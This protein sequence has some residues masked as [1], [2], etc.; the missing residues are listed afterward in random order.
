MSYLLFD[1]FDLLMLNSLDYVKHP[2]TFLNVLNSAY[3]V[4]KC[5][6][7]HSG[8]SYMFLVATLNVLK[9]FKYP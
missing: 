6:E 4:L 5:V 1:V 3:D 8:A 2:Y 9:C 7:K